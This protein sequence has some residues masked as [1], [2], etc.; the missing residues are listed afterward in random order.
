[1]TMKLWHCPARLILTVCLLA[2]CAA[3][4]DMTTARSLQSSSSRTASR[5]M[6][7]AVE[8]PDRASLD[9]A[10]WVGNPM[11]HYP[12]TA[13][14]AAPAPVAGPSALD[15]GG[16][17]DPSTIRDLISETPLTDAERAR[18]LAW[19][20]LTMYLLERDYERA[21]PLLTT[22]AGVSA[23]RWGNDGARPLQQIEA[24]FLHSDQLWVR[25]G[26]RPEMTSIPATDEDGDGYPEIYA[27]LA[28]DP[29]APEL[30]ELIV[31]DY[32]GRPLTADEIESY[33]YALCSEWYPSLQ[34]YLLEGDEARPWPSARTDPAA[35]VE[36]AGQVISAPTAVIRGQ[37]Y[38]EA[39]YN[40]F[41]VAA[42]GAAAA[43]AGPASSRVSVAEPSEALAPGDGRAWQAELARWGGSWEEWHHS[44]RRFQLDVRGLLQDVPAD[45][46]GLEG[47]DDWL[48]FRGDLNYLLSRDLREQPDGKNPWPAIIDFRDQLQARGVDLLLVVIPAKPEV[49][50]DRLSQHAPGADGPWVTPYCRKLLSEL[51]EAGVQIVD[52][53][54]VFMAERD[55][56][57]GPLYMTQDTHWTN[58]G[59]RL[60]ASL[61][62][63]RIREYP[64]LAEVGARPDGWG[65]RPADFTR[66]GDIVPMLPEARRAA[67]RPMQ[68]SAQQ[69]VDP[70]GEPYTDDQS[71]PIVMLGDS[72]TG[73][74]HFEDCRHAGVSAHLARELGLPIDLIMAQGSG[75]RIRAQLARRGEN[76]LKGKRLVIWTMVSRDLYQ[77]WADWDLIT[78]P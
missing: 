55:S 52:L 46:S 4:D 14:L 11:F 26:F 35:A 8:S 3:A 6:V 27:R 67:Y 17:L 57:E 21:A 34:T 16:A 58:R 43:P 24:A 66:L 48:F 19:Q 68:L 73:V 75:P 7:R 71:S 23:E 28:V 31:D 72:F 54:P 50:P 25:V 64:W 32:C 74:F 30:L 33:F 76:G 45:L 9:A 59:A 18:P 60:A 78:L 38:G 53:L 56:P 70:A 61:I 69:V 51:D 44:L 37:P 65:V 47:R 49:Y 63:R 22:G 40:V 29:L 20:P 2:S 13:P 77:Y 62:A 36:A 12:L 15:F 41:V 10:A 5:V 42:A 1:M 39:V